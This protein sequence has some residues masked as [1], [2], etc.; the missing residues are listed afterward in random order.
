MT[1][2]WTLAIPALAIVAWAAGT[3]QDAKTVI[4][5]ATKAL[6]ADNLKTVEFSGSGFDYVIGQ[7]ANPNLP[8]PKFIDKTYTRVVDLDA[9]SVTHAE[10]PSAG[11][12]SSARRRRAACHRR[13]KPDP[14]IGWGRR[15]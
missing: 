2:I 8:W 3:Q 5:G 9:T 11:G 14:G 12:E 10:G 1:K 6:G 13:A 4:G 7:A 15:T